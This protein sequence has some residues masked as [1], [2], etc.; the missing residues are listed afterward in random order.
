MPFFFEE[1]LVI[2]HRRFNKLSDH[3]VWEGNMSLLPISFVEIVA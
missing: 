3:D 2:Y 1:T